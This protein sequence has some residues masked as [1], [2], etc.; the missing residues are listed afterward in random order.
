MTDKMQVPA[1]L[2]AALARRISDG[3]FLWNRRQSA[4]RELHTVAAAFFTAGQR[5]TAA[6]LKPSQGAMMVSP[7]CT[8]MHNARPG[9]M[10]VQLWQPLRGVARA[11]ST[12]EHLKPQK[13]RGTAL[14]WTTISRSESEPNLHRAGD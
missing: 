12:T 14:R 3:S 7:A 1:S 2:A 6:A 11:Q 4:K 5:H 10:L 9:C 8:P 13:T